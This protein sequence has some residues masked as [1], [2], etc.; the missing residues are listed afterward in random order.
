MFNMG[1]NVEM[2]NKKKKWMNRKSGENKIWI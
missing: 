2:K 1:K